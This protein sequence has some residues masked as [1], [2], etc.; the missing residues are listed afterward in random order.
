MENLNIRKIAEVAGVSKSTVSRALSD[1][2]HVKEETRIKVKKVADELGYKRNPMVDSLMKQVRQRRTAHYV[3]TVAIVGPD[4]TIEVEDPVIR[5]MTDG[6]IACAKEHNFKTEYFCLDSNE[7]GK[8]RAL[9]KVLESRGIRGVWFLRNK[10]CP[11]FELSWE[12]LV[13]VAQGYTLSPPIFDRIAPHHYDMLTKLNANLTKR[14]Y[15]RIGLAIH[16]NRQG[17]MGY[18][19]LAAFN[20]YQQQIPEEDCIP[21]L[22]V[23]RLDFNGFKAWYEQYQPD[24]I[25]GQERVRQWAIQLGLQFPEDVG[26]V[27]IFSKASADESVSSP[28]IDNSVIGQVSMK[29][30]INRLLLNETGLPAFPRDHLVHYD[31]NEGTTV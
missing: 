26:F 9:D 18:T 11:Q 10:N 19:G 25:V 8:C 28:R 23:S 16:S 27:R 1:D 6:A 2:P 24:V 4:K 31:W 14:G 12:R 13:P 17:S 29:L 15:K 3:E 5:R 21:F 7:P 22:D 30:I 20:V